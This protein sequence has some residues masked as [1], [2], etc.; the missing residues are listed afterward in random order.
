MPYPQNVA[1]CTSKQ[2]WAAAFACLDTGET[3]HDSMHE[4]SAFVQDHRAPS[5]YQDRL[6]PKIGLRKWLVD[7]R[8]GSGQPSSKALGQ[9]RIR[10]LTCAARV[11]EMT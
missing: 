1:T 5:G 2:P 9:D 6:P 10:G 7:R 3:P 11:E 4:A 8:S